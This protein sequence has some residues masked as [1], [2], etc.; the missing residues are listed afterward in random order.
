[1]LQAS[2]GSRLES[3]RYVIYLTSQNYEKKDSSGTLCALFKT[4]TTKN[5]TGIYTHFTECCK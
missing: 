2:P 5:E 3:S 4:Y 1:M